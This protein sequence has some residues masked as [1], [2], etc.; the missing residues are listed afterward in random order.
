MTFGRMLGVLV[1]S[2]LLVTSA[3]LAGSKANGA[4][5]DS[6]HKKAEHTLSKAGPAPVPHARPQLKPPEPIV[7]GR[8]VTVHRKT[9]LHH[10]KIKPLESAEHQG[11]ADKAR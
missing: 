2:S 8:S 11:T 5:K 7:M 6:A 3:A 10:L 9:K 4:H 1:L